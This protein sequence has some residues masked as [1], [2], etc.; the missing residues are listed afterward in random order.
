MGGSD[1]E[2]AEALQRSRSALTFADK[3]TTPLL[4]LHAENDLRC[5]FSESFQLFV[6]LRKRKHIVEL[7]RY[8][9]VS[10]LLDLPDYG[11][12]AQRVDRL[13]RTIEWFE[14]FL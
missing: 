2:G 4:L 1:P 9:G 8:P 14:R 10:H 5:P 12:P 7:I 3:I 13:R 6:T 11:S